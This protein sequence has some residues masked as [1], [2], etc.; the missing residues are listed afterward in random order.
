MVIQDLLP[1]ETVDSSPRPDDDDAGEHD[2]GVKSEG[3]DGGVKSEG[4]DEDGGGTDHGGDVLVTEDSGSTKPCD[5]HPTPCDDLPTVSTHPI[6]DSPSTVMAT[7]ESEIKPG[8]AENPVS[9]LSSRNETE[10]SS[11]TPEGSGGGWG[12][13]GGWGGS[14]WSS[15]STVAESAQAIGQKVC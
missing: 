13:W 14:L 1:Q 8:L 2:G 9:S 4:G 11:S 5:D 15:V 7:A 12:G 10:G 3:S 6:S